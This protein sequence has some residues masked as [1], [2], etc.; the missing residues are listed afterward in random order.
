MKQRRIPVIALSI[1][2]LLLVGCGK[3]ESEVAEQKA[4]ET[5]QAQAAQV[6]PSTVGTVAGKVLFSGEKPKLGR[7][8]MDQDP[9]CSQKHSAPVFAEDGAVN[10]DGIVDFQD[11]DP[12][13]GLLSSGAT[14]P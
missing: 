3:K 5:P 4:P 13:V 2:L 14:C 7:L 8:R 10:G 9:V 1:G 6:D 12:F 11:I